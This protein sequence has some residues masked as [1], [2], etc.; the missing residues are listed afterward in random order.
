MDMQ[1]VRCVALAILRAENKGKKYLYRTSAS[2]VQ[3]RLG[4][5]AKQLLVG[6]DIAKGNKNGGIIFVGS[7]VP[8][9]AAQLNYLVNNTDITPIEVNVIN[10]LDDQNYLHEV[11]TVAA[12]ADELIEKGRDTV[13]YT[14]RKSFIS[15]KCRT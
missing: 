13:V 5:Q 11:E 2:F 15:A 6:K 7:Y 3:A 9:T 12:K 1:D 4:L 10:L 14:S 8:K